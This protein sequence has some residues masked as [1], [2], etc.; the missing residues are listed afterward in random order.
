VLALVIILLAIEA[1]L[2]ATRLRTLA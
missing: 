2:A 1:L